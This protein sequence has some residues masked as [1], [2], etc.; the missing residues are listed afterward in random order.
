LQ[1]TNI[2]MINQVW[3]SEK[4]LENHIRSDEYRNFLMALEMAP[5]KPEI[6]FDT[7]LSSS[8]IETI[9]RARSHPK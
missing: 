6:R 7:I 1:E 5:Q 3:K 2:L 8:G 4:N 9:K